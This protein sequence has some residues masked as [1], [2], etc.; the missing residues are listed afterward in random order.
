[1]T[2]KEIKE[3]KEETAPILG[4]FEAKKAAVFGSGRARRRSAWERRKNSR[5]GVPSLQFVYLF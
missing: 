1:M 2:V 4:R 3:I 5:G